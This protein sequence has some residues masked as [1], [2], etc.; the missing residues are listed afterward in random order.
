MTQQQDNLPPIT[1]EEIAL[2]QEWVDGPDGASLED[3][4]EQFPRLLKEWREMKTLSFMEDGRL[5]AFCEGLEM[6]NM[7]KLMTGEIADFFKIGQVMSSRIKQ[8]AQKD[9]VIEKMKKVLEFYSDENNTVR[10][11]R[12]GNTLC[13]N[14]ELSKPA[15]QCLEEIKG[16]KQA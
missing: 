8:L 11:C 3:I 14:V 9:A 5:R 7:D 1:E 13:A 6:Q 10:E 16:E 2:W 15:R 12:V 4:A